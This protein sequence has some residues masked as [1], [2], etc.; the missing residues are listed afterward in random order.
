MN[1]TARAEF[2][3]VIKRVNPFSPKILRY[4]YAG[5]Y[6]YEL[7]EGEGFLGSSKIYGVTLVQNN[8]HE[9][10]LGKCFQSLEEANEYIKSFKRSH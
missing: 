9:Y 8:T 1:T 3:K 6:V 5:K 7:S 10:E 2:K 4:G